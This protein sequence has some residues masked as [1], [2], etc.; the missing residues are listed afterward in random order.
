MSDASDRF[1]VEINE[2]EGKEYFSKNMN[3]KRFTEFAS[4]LEGFTQRIVIHF[5]N[6]KD[7]VYNEKKKMLEKFPELATSSNPSSG[8]SK[9]DVVK[10]KLDSSVNNE[11]RMCYRNVEIKTSSPEECV[12]TVNTLARAVENAH[13]DILYYSS[14]QGQILSNLKDCCGQSFTVILRNNIN[15]SKSHAYFFMKF[16]KLALEY[17][18]LLKC[19]LPLSYFQK[20]FANIK[21]ICENEKIVWK[22]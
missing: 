12:E 22:A 9:F 21:L 3:K 7:F 16:H 15:I 13:R 19:E 4:Y 14:I 11:R 18:R 8:Q 5:P 2:V 1:F 17:P 20:N 10:Y 6:T